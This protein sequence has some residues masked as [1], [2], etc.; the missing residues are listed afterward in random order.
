MF[1]LRASSEYSGGGEWMARGDVA[2]GGG[3]LSLQT[4]MKRGEDEADELLWADKQTVADSKNA[5]TLT[6]K[7]QGSGTV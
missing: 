2:H 6:T 5:M 1:P 4:L 7:G 3:F